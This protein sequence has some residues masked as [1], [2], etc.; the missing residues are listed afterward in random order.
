MIIWVIPP[1]GCTQSARS[2]SEAYGTFGSNRSGLNAD[3]FLRKIMKKKKGPEKRKKKSIIHSSWSLLSYIWWLLKRSRLFKWLLSGRSLL[4][5]SPLILASPRLVS[6]APWAFA[7]LACSAHGRMRPLKELNQTLIFRT[8]SLQA[9]GAPFPPWQRKQPEWAKNTFLRS[10]RAIS[11]GL[12]GCNRQVVEVLKV[13]NDHPA[14]IMA[15][16]SWMG[17]ENFVP[18]KRF[19]AERSYRYPS[20]W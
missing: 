11:T 6:C 15:S 9:T 20:A 18:R 8:M 17:T 4:A 1:Q 13:F 16:S 19:G 3:L 12:P 10:K 7:R 5:T 14:G 2:K